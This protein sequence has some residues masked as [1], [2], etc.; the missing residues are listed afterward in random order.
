MQEMES[1]LFFLPATSVKY[2]LEVKYFK[3]DTTKPCN[4]FRFE[5]ATKPREKVLQELLCPINVATPPTDITFASGIDVD[6]HRDDYVFSA[7]MINSTARTFRYSIHLNVRDKTTLSAEIG[8]NFL[9]NDFRLVLRN[10]E[11]V[12]LHNSRVRGNANS[13]SYIN[14]YHTLRAELQPGTYYLDIEE[15]LLKKDLKINSTMCHRFSLSI[16]GISES[17]P[18]IIA[19]SPPGGTD[20]DPTRDLNIQITFSDPVSYPS[21]VAAYF[22]AHFPPDRAPGLALRYIDNSGANPDWN[23]IRPANVR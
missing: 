4:Y 17:T 10:G 3:I 14:F 13:N 1:G 21:D 6:I 2:L 16:M 9:A 7:A 5:L 23:W 22:L 20:L 15:D 8:F 11:R 18:H 12:V 19:I